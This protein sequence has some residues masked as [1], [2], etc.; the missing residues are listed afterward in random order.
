MGA[1]VTGYS[2]N[3]LSQPECLYKILYKEK[4][5]KQSVLNNKNLEKQLLNSQA[6]IV[7][8]MAAQSILSDASEDPIKNYLTNIIGTPSILEACAQKLRP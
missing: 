8:H 1:K 4:I 3:F 5:L 7:F 6:D 2:L